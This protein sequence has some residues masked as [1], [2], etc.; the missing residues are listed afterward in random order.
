MNVAL[1]FFSYMSLNPINFM[2]GWF[3]GLD[4]FISGTPFDTEGDFI[5]YIRRIENIP[6]QVGMETFN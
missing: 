2:E 1:F 3:V 5:N 6:R 4:L